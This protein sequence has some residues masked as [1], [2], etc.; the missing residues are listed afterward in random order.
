MDDHDIEDEGDTDSLL[1]AIGNGREAPCNDEVESLRFRTQELLLDDSNEGSTGSS[2]TTLPD[3]LLPHGADHPKNTLEGDLLHQ[4]P[5]PH[6]FP[7]PPPIRN[8]GTPAQRSP[9]LNNNNRRITQSRRLVGRVSNLHLAE[10][11]SVGIPR[12]VEENGPGRKRSL[13]KL[14]RTKL[15]DARRPWRRREYS[16]SPT[17]PPISTSPSPSAPAAGEQQQQAMKR[18]MTLGRLDSIGRMAISM[19]PS[20]ENGPPTTPWVWTSWILTC[21]IPGALLKW[22]GKGDPYVAQA[23]REKLT[24]CLIIT[25]LMA[26]VGFLTFGFQNSVCSF[27]G[28]HINLNKLN[29][30][31]ASTSIRGVIYSL[32]D[33]THPPIPGITANFNNVA[34]GRDITPLWPPAANTSKCV[35][36]LGAAYTQFPCVIP[37][38]WPPNGSALP[39]DYTSC[40]SSKADIAV[41]GLTK[42]QGTVFVDWE[43]VEQSTNML[44]Y[45]GWVLDLTAFSSNPAFLGQDFYAL[46]MA[47]IGRDATKAFSLN[48]TNIRKA[49]CLDEIFRVGQI[50]SQPFGCVVSNVVLYVSLIVI[51][52][53]VFIRFFLAITF[54]YLIGSR[55]GDRPGSI[56]RSAVELS[57]RRREIKEI[58][59]QDALIAA[60]INETGQPR[61]AYRERVPVIPSGLSGRL[62]SSER[63]RTLNKTR[64]LP[65]LSTRSFGLRSAAS[66]R[67][68]I[69]EE[70]VPDSEADLSAMPESK[71]H[72]AI[73]FGRK[74]PENL[75]I[76]SKRLAVFPDPSAPDAA[77]AKETVMSNP[78]L[79]HVLV[80]I[81][82]YSEPYISLRTTLDS[83]ANTYYPSTHKTL[84]VVAD[85]MVTGE[86]NG[87]P[88]SDFLVDM[89]EVDDRFRSD[90]PRYGGEPQAYSYVAIADGS[91][92][93]NFARVYAGWYRYTK[94]Q[95]GADAKEKDAK[96]KW[97]RSL[98]NL[99][100]SK[101]REF[102]SED[103]SDDERPEL[104]RHGTFRSIKTRKDGRVPMILVVKCGNPEEREPGNRKPGNRGKRDSQVLVMNFLSKVMFDDRLTE[105][106]F[107]LVHK[108]WAIGGV[109]PSKYEGVLMVDAD[110]KVYP[111]CITHMVACMLND[112]KVMGLCGETRIANK[113]GSWVTMIQ[114]FEYYISHHLTKA[115]ESVFGGV[116]CLP[117]CFCMYRIKAP[118]PEHEGTFVPLLANPDVVEQYSENVVDTLHKKNLLLLGEDRFLTTLMLKNFPHRK[119][120]FVP[121][122]VCKTVVPDSF[123]ILLSQRRRW[124][125]STIHNLLELILVRDLCGI[126]CFS[127]QFVI[128]MELVGTVVLP[129]AISFTIFLLIESFFISPPPYIPLGLLAAILGLPALLIVM[130]AHHPM[131]IFW[132]FIYLVSLPIWNFVLPL[133]AFWHFDDF[134]WGQTRQV[135]GEKK[136]ED[137]SRRTGEFD[138]EG[139]QLRRAADWI[140]YRKMQNEKARRL[141]FAQQ[142][143][144]AGVGGGGASNYNPNLMDPTSN[145]ESMGDSSHTGA[146]PFP[147]AYSRPQPSLPPPMPLRSQSDDDRWVDNSQSDAPPRRNPTVRFNASPVIERPSHL[148]NILASSG[149]IAPR[150]PD[151]SLTQ[152]PSPVKPLPNLPPQYTTRSPTRRTSLAHG[153]RNAWSAIQTPFNNNSRNSHLDNGATPPP[154]RDESLRTSSIPTLLR[155][156]PIPLPNIVTVWKPSE[157]DGSKADG[158]EEEDCNKT[159]STEHFSTNN[160]SSEGE[161]TPA[162]ASKQT[163]DH[164]GLSPPRT[165]PKESSVGWVPKLGFI[166]EGHDADDEE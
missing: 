67:S 4:T 75:R 140:R 144:T 104:S 61:D 161:E 125:N 92:R 166:E 1:Q 73:V 89:M 13:F 35:A 142:E 138:G 60:Q 162:T 79:M 107:E 12:N 133:Y 22:F 15:G 132:M 18:K 118:K 23:F 96:K 90:D 7:I 71:R 69:S 126:F 43:F 56:T 37:N 109:H 5:L 111:D 83:I 145:I 105:L 114:V 147:L 9:D 81:T 3:Y 130:T 65:V 135:A 116:T 136:G 24:L 11:L 165:P 36:L 95:P 98:G 54:S 16:R 49:Q 137:H 51:V 148:S 120:I 74:A 82:C 53:V 46:A 128:F 34:Q 19:R 64:S 10:S 102:D 164:A 38:V 129:A 122:A 78:D 113:F 57:R 55:L 31:Y 14:D 58:K 124:I 27:N 17:S 42:V 26:A 106:E 156:L 44:V 47:N 97:R 94:S 143:A 6:V 86:G 159:T 68:I 63:D 155:P 139:I 152:P 70:V 93:K 99:A 141:L 52:G 48:A 108:L 112:P 87:R 115:F 163:A 160:G 72:S 8:P 40:H 121:Q 117:G 149:A 131:Y 33:F 21:C 80:M 30:L 88:T 28:L 50:D 20:H 100:L 59:E 25:I 84:F 41:L 151:G 146:Y 134:S 123:K 77:A 103:D 158:V 127:M 62:I 110:T 153:V 2:G 91:K 85:G 29:T 101:Q 66:S 154:P 150:S 119:M 76:D 157:N 32:A 39:N 45:N